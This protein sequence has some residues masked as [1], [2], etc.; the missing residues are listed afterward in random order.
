MQSKTQV[1]NKCGIKKSLAEYSPHKGKPFGVKYTCK[2][3]QAILAK[4]RRKE[5]PFSEPQKEKARV[6]SQIWRKENKDKI[7]LQKKRWLE[8]NRHKKAASSARYRSSKLKATPSW[9]S[10]KHLQEIN[11][12]YLL[13]NEVRMLTGDDYHV[14]HIVPL[15]GDN[16]CGLHVPW[17]LQV[18]PAEINLSKK[19]RFDHE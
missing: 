5:K 17:N 7:P 16:I 12:F 6:R 3:C 14:D 1:C 11:N 8:K 18:L 19:N 4:K 10:K 9:L 13:R 15:K 2:V